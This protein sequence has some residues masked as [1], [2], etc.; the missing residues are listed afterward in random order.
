MIYLVIL[1]FL[2]FIAYLVLVFWRKNRIPKEIDMALDNIK[3]ALY[4][5]FSF[6]Y[7][8]EYGDPINGYLSAGVVNYIFSEQTSSEQGA[9]FHDENYKLICSEARNVAKEEYICRV[10]SLAV[11]ARIAIL[12]Q[13][14]EKDP[15]EVV[16]AATLLHDLGIMELDYETPGLYYFLKQSVLILGV[17]LRY[18]KGEIDDY[19]FEAEVFNIFPSKWNNNK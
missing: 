9:K 3:Y 18:V 19:N 12:Y 13:Q 10:I 16:S 11:R 1:A 4:A 15:K 7:V 14:K 2:I 8:D 17:T 6:K 5:L